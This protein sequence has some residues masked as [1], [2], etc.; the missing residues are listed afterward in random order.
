MARRSRE[1]S[2]REFLASP[3]FNRRNVS[4]EEIRMFDTALT[5][6]S[7]S[8]EAASRGE[9]EGSYERLEFLGD[10][11]L[12]LAVCEHIF[13]NTDLSEGE[14]TA[15]KIDKVCNE[16]ISSRVKEYGM[17]IDDVIL[18]GEGH[19]DRRTSRNIIEDGMRADAFEAVL[20]AVYLLY[21]MDEARRIV[22][23][24]FLET[25]R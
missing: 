6:D 10:A 12:G 14:M 7:H 4:D 11:V 24:M 17:D 16:N 3:P 8:N 2:I 13:S 5:H 9:K 19:K 15:F 25:G 1:M 21:G 20:G 23:E 18:V 22:T